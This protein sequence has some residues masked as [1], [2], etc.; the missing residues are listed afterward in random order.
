MK[1]AVQSSAAAKASTLALA[2][3]LALAGC[4]G[5]R[6]DMP[7]APPSFNVQPDDVFA[8]LRDYRIGPTDLIGVTVYR[9]TDLSGDYRIDATGNIMMPLA[10]KIDLTGMTSTEA[11]AA[12][13]QRLT[14]YYVNP[15]VSITMKEMTGQR[16]TVMG[17]VNSP[18]NYPIRPG[19]SLLQA[20]ASANGLSGGANAHRVAIFR[21]IDGQKMAAAFDLEDISNARM[22]DPIVYASDIIIVDGNQ[23]RQALR[24]VLITLPIIGLFRPLLY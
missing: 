8:E 15:D 23:T 22:E 17:A 18:G 3:C 4:A 13:A 6:S 14:A 20:V 19:S 5:R 7:Y 12:I 24:D 1:F 2:V 21:Q 11:S 10:G 16:I 9:A